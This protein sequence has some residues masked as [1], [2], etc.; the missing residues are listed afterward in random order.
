MNTIF[1]IGI[2]LAFFISLLLATKKSTTL[3]DRILS[4]WMF[5]IGINLLNY[6]FY[7]IGMWDRYP[8]LIGVTAPIPLLHGPMLF[9]YT[10]SSL[11]GENKLRV[12]DYL[13][14]APTILSY[15]YLVKFFF[16]YSADQK[17][18]VDLGLV[19]DFKIFS[20]LTLIAI[21]LSGLIYP[22]LSYFVLG[23]YRKLINDNFSYEHGISLDWLKYSI[24]GIGAIYCVAAATITIR[25]VFGIEFPFRADYIFYS[26]TIIFV[27]CIGYFGIRQ[28]NLFFNN[29][30]NNTILVQ[31]KNSGEY[32]KSGLKPSVAHNIHEK[33]QNLMLYEKPYKNPKLT[34]SELA[35]AVDT[36]PNHLSQIIN[37]KE[38][39]NFHD[40]VNKYRVEEFIQEASSNPNFNILAHALDAGFNSKSSFNNVF[41]KHKDIT[42]SKY[43]SNLASK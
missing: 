17:I 38:N 33:L 35:K 42:P 28:Q 2:F 8:H 15:L 21:L 5:L 14:F 37:Q 6:Y 27:F 19:D 7:S 32:K 13:H 1:T 31:K 26:M 18:E 4:I 43:L 34:L 39:M 41:K 36:T 11:R 29:G 20:I 3:S 16:F 9:L 22:I 10:I 24:W 30:N 23:K 25:D 12:N 40:F